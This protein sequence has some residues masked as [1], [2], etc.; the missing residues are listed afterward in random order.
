MAPEICR[1]NYPS[2]LEQP[3]TLYRTQPHL[4]S[5]YQLPNSLCPAT[6]LPAGPQSYQFDS[7]FRTFAHNA[8]SARKVLAQASLWFFSSLSRNSSVVLSPMFAITVNILTSCPLCSI[9]SLPYSLFPSVI[10]Y[11]YS[12]GALCVLEREP[13]ENRS[14]SPLHP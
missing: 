10:C 12:I 4:S 1:G 2:F 6:P 7:S 8:H 3:I 9:L 11:I 5:H 14:F 13:Q